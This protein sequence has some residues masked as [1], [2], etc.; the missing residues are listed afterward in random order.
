MDMPHHFFLQKQDQGLK[1]THQDKEFYTSKSEQN[2]VEQIVSINIFFSWGSHIFSFFSSV[3]DH[4]TLHHM[5]SGEWA[6]GNIGNEL[7]L[8]TQILLRN[9]YLLISSC[10]S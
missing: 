3:V 1:F 6:V 2:P 9:I 8:Y 4:E 5:L 7:A 10:F